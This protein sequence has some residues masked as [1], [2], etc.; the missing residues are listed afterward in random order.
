MFACVCARARVC[1]CARVCVSVFVSAYVCAWGRACVRASV[2]STTRPRAMPDHN[3]STYVD[4]AQTH[5]A[6]EA[7]K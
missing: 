7:F 2:S 4:N 6:T 3:L 5:K 1:L